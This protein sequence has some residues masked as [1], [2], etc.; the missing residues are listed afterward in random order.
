MVV[1]ADAQSIVGSA[2]RHPIEPIGGAPDLLFVEPAVRADEGVDEDVEA[3]G[4]GRL[5]Y[6]LLRGRGYHVVAAAPLVGEEGRV[7]SLSCEAV[8][9]KRLGELCG[10]VDEAE[11]LDITQTHAGQP[12]ECA[13]EILGELVVHCVDLDGEG[14]LVHGS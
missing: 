2:L 1:V 8:A 12:G 4:L 7:A 3:Q 6:V 5:E 13:V 11:G 10:P 14:G 9:G